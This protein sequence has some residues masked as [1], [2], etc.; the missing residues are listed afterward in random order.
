MPP[1][2]PGTGH[3]TPGDFQAFLSRVKVIPHP[4]KPKEF[5]DQDTL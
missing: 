5:D 1:A 4:D 2:A 3:K